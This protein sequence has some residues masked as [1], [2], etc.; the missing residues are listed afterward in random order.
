MQYTPRAS[1]INSWFKKQKNEDKP[2]ETT[3]TVSHWLV[4]KKINCRHKNKFSGIIKHA[5]CINEKV[6]Y[7]CS[8]KIPSLLYGNLFTIIWQNWD[9]HTRKIYETIKPYKR[10]WVTRKLSVRVRGNLDQR[11]ST[12]FSASQHFK[13]SI[14]FTIC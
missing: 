6:A 8:S 2:T 9:P 12:Y 7:K 4:G 14:Q 3:G 13:S 10:Q 1:S 5:G 11:N